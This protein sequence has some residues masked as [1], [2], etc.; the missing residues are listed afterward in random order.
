[1]KGPVVEYIEQREAISCQAVLGGKLP[2][3]RQL[4]PV[5]IGVCPYQTNR[6]IHYTKLG[7]KF[8]R[9]QLQEFVGIVL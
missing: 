6:Y 8:L 4:K 7:E 9:G 2:V 5:T 1:M 3:V